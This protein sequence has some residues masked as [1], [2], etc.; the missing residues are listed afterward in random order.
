MATA[1]GPKILGVSPGRTL[2]AL[3]V[4]A[5]GLALT[6]V[7]I[8]LVATGKAGYHPV[9]AQLAAVGALL[10]VTAL[11][12]IPVRKENVATAEIPWKDAG[13]G[14]HT[15]DAGWLVPPAIAATNKNK[16][17]PENV[18]ALRTLYLGKDNR[19]STS[20]VVALAWTYA[21][22]YGLLSLIA[23]KLMGDSRAWDTLTGAGLQEDYLLLL[24]GPYAA[25]V[26]AKYAAVAGNAADTKTSDPQAG[27]SMGK[28]T[29]NLIAD[30]EGDTD[31][32]DFQYVLFNIVALIF[33]L[34]TFIE[35]PKQGFPDLPSLLIGLALTS[36]ATYTAKQAA[37]SA[38]GPQ[39]TSVFPTT[40]KTLPGTVDVFGRNL[41]ENGAL[42]M[43]SIDGD[44]MTDVTVGAASRAGDHLMFKVP[45]GTSDKEYT[46]RVMTANGAVART[47]GGAEFLTLTVATT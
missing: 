38:A 46:V 40:L 14:D 9:D 32:G 34:G 17:A 1:N 10:L 18:S 43:I 19:T 13:G 24:G 20:K 29:K 27:P 44:R 8:L 41:V 33:F 45:T 42:P 6:V 3:L 22:V 37:V 11:L 35:D 7:P 26:I 36:A 12:M 28:D 15:I 16:I 4:I 23:M 30:D 21:I 25:A 47:A 5:G 31:L 39:L 2:R